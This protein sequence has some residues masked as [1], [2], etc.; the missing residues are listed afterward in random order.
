MSRRWRRSGRILFGTLAVCG[1]AWIFWRSSSTEP[2]SFP[3][4][5]QSDIR[6]SAAAA[7][8]QPV[9]YVLW[10]R[11]G[12]FS[13]FQPAGTSGAR[14]LAAEYSGMSPDAG[15]QRR[16]DDAKKADI[17]EWTHAKGWLEWN[18]EVPEDG[19]YD[20]MI[21]YAPMK[22]S[23]S[24]IVR[25][26][27]IDGKYPFAEAGRI[28][29]D[30]QW[31]DA[32][33]PYDRNGIGNEIRPVQEERSG[34]QTARVTDYSLSSEPL[35]WALTKGPHTIRLVGVKEPV[36]LYSLTLASPEKLPAYAEYAGRHPAG[37]GPQKDWYQRY[38]A[39]Q[40]LQKSAV[41]TR[42]IS[43]AEPL[44]SP[45]AKGKITYNALG[46]TSWEKAG[47][48]VEWEIAVPETGYY[49]IDL[50]YF[51]G[52]NGNASVY[53]TVLI[54]DQVPFREMLHYRFAPNRALEIKPLADPDGE[55]YLF[56]LTEGTHR[57]KL[58]ADNSLVRPAVEALHEIRQRVMSIEKEIRAISGNYG[59]GADQNIDTARTWEIK[60]FDPEI[61][62]KLQSV[63][64]EMEV[65]RDYLLGLNQA[66]TDP[67]TAL[68]ALIDLVRSLKQ[69]V[70]EI[71]NQVTAFS[72]IVSGIGTWIKPVESQAL[73]LDYI[74][75]RT[76]Q[77]NPPFQIPNGWDKVRYTAVNFA[78]SFFEN[79]DTN[80]L[81]D[82]NALTIWVQRG[83]D[84]VDLLQSLIEQEFTPQTGIKVNVNLIPNQ[85]VLLMGNA[86]G[87]QPDLALGVGMETPVDF[88]MRGA[89]EDLSQYD[90][91]EEVLKRFNPG[92]MRSY[93]YGGGVY[94]LPE[95]QTYNMMF[96]RTDIFEQLGIEPPDTWDDLMRLL[97]TLQERG[98][99]FKY[100]RK[101]DGTI[102][103]NLTTSGAYSLHY[104][105]PF[106]QQGAEFYTEDGLQTELTSTEGLAAFK[107]YT[108]WFSKY[109]LPQEVPAFINH[110]RYGDM[111][112]G[113]SD[114]MLNIQL[115]VA[116]P[117]LAGHWKMVP[118]P[119]TRQPDGTVVRWAPQ[120]T[121]S[122][123]MMKQSKRK[124]EAWKFLEWWTSGSVQSRY[125]N[126]IESYA[127][128]E[129][130]WYTANVA[131]MQTLPWS[132]DDLKALNE[133]DRWAKNV[134]YVPGYYFLTRE[135]DFA[136]INTVI[137]GKPARETLGKSE[138]S[139]QREMRRKQEEFG[140]TPDDN[141]QV[142]PYNQPYGRE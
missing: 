55:P 90:G 11:S 13:R 14:V 5:A 122:A 29:L 64:D 113:I 77:T 1:I 110:F 66:V 135:M 81:N 96:Y 49:A 130:R 91:F 119:G 18:V 116:A 73:Q 28:V 114:F 127:G 34:W 93:N 39:E 99:S 50:K 126:D 95:T 27:Q 133:Q 42:T 20:L 37:S 61:E 17:V 70:N 94:G 79:Y 141:L 109:S 19:L 57:L 84:Y 138:M 71:P 59:F 100:P 9:P 54:D 44:V 76:P 36:A 22:G 115:T 58:V 80:E 16:R 4:V 8:R 98:M 108:E 123:F 132:E 24:E 101:I 67:T 32:K 23:F 87:D 62:N 139:L 21:E 82:E 97:P 137:G 45:D 104:A 125:G 40:F 72:D 92:I 48:S 7:D 88:A 120:E 41:S 25:G 69:D 30:R 134:P 38:E 121:T 47:Q 107:Q 124:E 102:H 53:R 2:A 33:Y 56:H 106:Y 105:L 43:V 117:E 63:N 31:R 52:Y 12:E 60:K 78:R 26:V 65:V 86:A 6:L 46:G 140:L 75:V 128:I 129:Y 142:T 74:V 3:V 85:N 10:Q 68:S 89:A 51:Q 15:V 136:W 112:I 83:R 103:S 35:R 131:A 118:V 111:P